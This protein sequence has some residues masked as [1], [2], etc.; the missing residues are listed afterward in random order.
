MKLY[1][2]NVNAAGDRIV[3]KEYDAKECKK[4][5]KVTHS[6]YGWEQIQKS[7]VGPILHSR[8]AGAYAWCTHD[9]VRATAEKIRQRTREDLTEQIHRL[10]DQ[11]RELADAPLGFVSFIKHTAQGEEV[12]DD[13]F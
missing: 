10:Q 5:I 6:G 3:V 2:V 11:R 1:R 4:I 13:M 12:T 8:F 7:D 9:D